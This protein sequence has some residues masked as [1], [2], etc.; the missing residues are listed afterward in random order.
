[1]YILQVAEPCPS[2][3]ENRVR[4]V[5]PCRTRRTAQCEGTAPHEAIMA[6]IR[7]A[8]ASK[9]TPNIIAVLDLSKPNELEAHKTLHRAT[10]GR[11]PLWRL[12]GI[13]RDRDTLILAVEWKPRQPS[14]PRNWSLIFFD[15]CDRSI[16]WRDFPTAT[17][18]RAALRAQQ[19]AA[20]QGASAANH[21]AKRQKA[22]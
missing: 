12:L 4:Q 2:Q 18:A 8:S 19:E 1:M 16:R 11:W 21:A 15:L 22:G 5:A 17:A 9:T 3:G 20:Q 6:P 13:R 10:T 7:P 14:A